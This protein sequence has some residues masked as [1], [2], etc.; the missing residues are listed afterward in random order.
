MYVMC[1]YNAID[2]RKIARQQSVQHLAQHAESLE[3]IQ[4]LSEKEMDDA[5]D[6]DDNLRNNNVHE[7]NN[8]S[9]THE[10]EVNHPGN[11]TH[12]ENVSL[13][14]SI[15]DLRNFNRDNK[16]TIPKSMPIVRSIEHTESFSSNFKLTDSVV[17]GEK[18]EGWE[19]KTSR[20]ASTATNFSTEFS[21]YQI[22]VE[23]VLT[24]LLEAEDFFLKRSSRFQRFGRGQTAIPQSRGVY[25][26]TVRVSNFRLW[27]SRR[28]HEIDKRIAI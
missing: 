20:P 5:T 3:E 10:G 25:E 9:T 11:D 27:R 4:L 23:E 21:G 1:L 22:A 2:S 17:L 13:A 8:V 12:L 16:I 19:S 24:M 15:D 14:K 26:E 7:Q 6:T 18:V 28:R